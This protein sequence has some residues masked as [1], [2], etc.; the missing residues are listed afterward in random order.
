MWAGSCLAASGSIGGAAAA[1]M[2]SDCSGP[3]GILVQTVW[4]QGAEIQHGRSLAH[5]ALQ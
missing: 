3:S 1:G 5:G 4:Q 2:N